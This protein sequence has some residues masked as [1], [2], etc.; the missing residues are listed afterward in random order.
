MKIPAT[1]LKNFSMSET[2]FRNQT[3]LCCTTALQKYAPKMKSLLALYRKHFYIAKEKTLNRSILAAIFCL[4]FQVVFL[5][6]F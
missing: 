6:T 2:K 3:K 4:I 5:S 1:K